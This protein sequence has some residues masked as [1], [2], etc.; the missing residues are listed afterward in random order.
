M[1]PLSVKP[2]GGTDLHYLDHGTGEPVLLLHGVNCGAL[3]W[4]DVARRL[5]PNF[6]AVAPDLPG[7]GD[8]PPPPGFRYDVGQLADFMLQA[9]DA[10][11]LPQASV[12]GWSF[13]GCLAVHMALKAPERIRKLVL[14][15]PG[16]L[17]EDVH[18]SYKLMALP[19]FG[20]WSM[21]P[22]LENIEGGL[23][24]L[25]G[26]IT[27][28]PQAF[29]SHIAKAAQNPWFRRTTLQW[30]R[31]NRVLWEGARRICVG[32]RLHEVRSPTLIIWGAEDPLVPVAH[33]ETAATIPGSR[34]VIVPGCRHIVHFEQPD[35]FH[36]LLMEFLA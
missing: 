36:S 18:W 30:V 29:S 21:R 8:T 12:V 33:A 22:T 26:N 32:G 34:L 24:Y 28:V 20:E 35:L 2:V 3:V 10:M 31:R 23:S 27:C 6:R 25:T 1:L 17:R 4:H 5:A 16:G 19:G 13:G 15:A 9:M 11:N 14:V 7:W